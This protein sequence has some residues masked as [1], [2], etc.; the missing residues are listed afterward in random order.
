M[1]GQQMDTF[2][3][4]ALQTKIYCSASVNSE[5]NTKECRQGKLLASQALESGTALKQTEDCIQLIEHWSLDSCIVGT[6]F[7]STAKNTGYIKG[8][9]IADEKHL[10]C[11]LLYL[12][13]R[14][15]VHE[16]VLREVWE[17]IF[18]KEQGPTYTPLKNLHNEGSKKESVHSPNGDCHWPC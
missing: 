8:T 4:K 9:A 10:C 16:L 12:A 18:G 2:L 11:R 14:H 7:D 13:C 6:C 1:I 17:M 15:H 5:I 3:G